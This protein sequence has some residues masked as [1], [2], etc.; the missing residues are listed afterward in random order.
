MLIVIFEQMSIA[1]FFGD[2]VKGVDD[3]CG[4]IEWFWWYIDT[5]NEFVY[6]LWVYTF[7]GMHFREVL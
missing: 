1:L 6:K 5:Q 2:G 7:L 4:T 3:I